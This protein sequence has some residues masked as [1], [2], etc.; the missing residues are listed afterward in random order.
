MVTSFI[1]RQMLLLLI[2][3]SAS[4]CC[5]SQGPRRNAVAANQGQA[6]TKQA[7]TTTNPKPM[8]LRLLHNIKGHLGTVTLGTGH[9]YYSEPAV[10]PL[11]YAYAYPLWG[12]YGYAPFWSGS[13]S[14][15]LFQAY[16]PYPASSA[17]SGEGHVKLRV[18]P[19]TA[20]VLINNAY[21]GT[22]ADLKG[23][24]WLKPGTYDLCIKAPGRQ[25][26][27]RRI[28]VQSGKKLEI[29]ARLARANGL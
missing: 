23:G 28:Q 17:K 15:P 6:P 22:V 2:L 20:E 5:A 21:V 3:L 27:R 8:I 12:Y 19:R 16:P 4:L 13:Y 11:Y 14:G 26:F 9:S 1:R 7:E 29:Q 18:N 24:I 10:L 25:E